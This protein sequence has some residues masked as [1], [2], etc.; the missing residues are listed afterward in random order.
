MN[1][2][3]ALLQFINQGVKLL[4]SQPLGLKL[5]HLA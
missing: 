2:C 3:K 5:A 1:V 4:P